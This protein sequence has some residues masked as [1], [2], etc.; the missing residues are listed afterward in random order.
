MTAP[1]TAPPLDPTPYRLRDRLGDLFH[2]WRDGANGLPRLLPTDPPDPPAE[3]R[4]SAPPGVEGTVPVEQGP[5]STPR[6]RALKSQTLAAIAVEEQLLEESVAT[7]RKMQAKEKAEQDALPPVIDCAELGVQAAR[8]PPTGQDL[9]LRRLA[10]QDPGKRPDGLIRLR[11]SGDHRRR[12]AKAENAHLESLRRQAG[13]TRTDDALEEVIAHR[14]AAAQAAAHRIY[15]YGNRR[16]ATY[17]QQLV[18][19]HKQGGELNMVLLR[20]PVGPELPAWVTAERL[21]K[22]G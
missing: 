4:E 18:R 1:W 16:I 11:R 9:T 12:L 6:I 3:H 15:H 17:L 14:R 22:G 19:S 7:L 5:I 2:G 21:P 13:A 8:I 10:E 20:H